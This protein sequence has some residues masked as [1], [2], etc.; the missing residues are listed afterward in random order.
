M[1]TSDNLSK[2]NVTDYVKNPHGICISH[3]DNAV[4]YSKFRAVIFNWYAEEF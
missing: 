1:Y 3:Y 2:N 4:D